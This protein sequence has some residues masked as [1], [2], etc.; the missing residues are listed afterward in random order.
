MPKIRQAEAKTVIGE[1]RSAAYMKYVSTGA[2]TSA[3]CSPA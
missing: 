3:V 1:H 2:Q